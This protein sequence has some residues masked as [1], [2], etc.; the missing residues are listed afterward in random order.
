M[1]LSPIK[2]KQI[3]HLLVGC[4][5]YHF[6]RYCFSFTDISN[7]DYFSYVTTVSLFAT[8]ADVTDFITVAVFAASAAVADF[9]DSSAVTTVSDSSDVVDAVAFTAKLN[10]CHNL[11][12]LYKV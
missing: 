1:I 6:F 9:S 7:F 12:I 4:C 2:L 10:Q 11:E 3:S 5:L 8:D